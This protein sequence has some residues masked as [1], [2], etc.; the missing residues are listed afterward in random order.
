[1]NLTGSS[2]TI[3]MPRDDGPK[4]FSRHSK[5]TEANIDVRSSKVCFEI[6]RK[7]H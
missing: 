2:L 6:I 5:G 4:A 1:M 7:V 3:S